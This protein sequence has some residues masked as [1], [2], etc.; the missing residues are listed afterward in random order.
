MT[1]PARDGGVPSH[2]SPSLKQ[3]KPRKLRF[4]GRLCLIFSLFFTCSYV[5]DV[6]RAFDY[7][8]TGEL[9]PKLNVF[10][11]EYSIRS[12][13]LPGRFAEKVLRCALPAGAFG[14]SLLLLL[15]GCVASRAPDRVRIHRCEAV[16]WS[17]LGAF[18]LGL[19]A[20]TSWIIW[21]AFVFV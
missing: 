3:R 1:D 16:A 17:A 15:L 9:P 12:Y 11:L 7:M 2:S 5:R 8:T 20:M 4:A 6:P 14:F 10:W 21:K 13:F 18:L 19:N